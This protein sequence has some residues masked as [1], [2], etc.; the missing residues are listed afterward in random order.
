MKKM[1]LGL[2]AVVVVFIA[3]ILFNTLTFKSAQLVAEPVKKVKIIGKPWHFHFI[4]F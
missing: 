1:F 2:L 4:C 3:Y